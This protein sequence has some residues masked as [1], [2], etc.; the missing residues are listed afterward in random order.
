MQRINNTAEFVEY[1]KH[2]AENEKK[3]EEELDVVGTRKTLRVQL[4]LGKRRDGD[5]ICI[6][7]DFVENGV[8]LSSEEL[9]QSQEE[10]DVPS[11]KYS[12]K[13]ASERSKQKP[14]NV[15]TWL[16]RLYLDVNSEL[17]H[18]LLSE[19][20]LAMKDTLLFDNDLYDHLVMS[21]RFPPDINSVHM[22]KLLAVVSGMH[23]LQVGS[24]ILK[25]KKGLFLPSA[26]NV[27][28]PQTFHE[29][30]RTPQGREQCSRMQQEGAARGGGR[31]RMV[32]SVPEQILARLGFANSVNRNTNHAHDNVHTVVRRKGIVEIDTGIKSHKVAYLDDENADVHMGTKISDVIQKVGARKWRTVDDDEYRV[33]H[34]RRENGSTFTTYKKDELKRVSIGELIEYM[35]LPRG[36]VLKIVHGSEKINDDDGDD[37]SF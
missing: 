25:P 16:S 36:Q 11:E 24:E 37:V 31:G 29:W 21:D 4:A 22:K 8:V 20:V 15:K 6:S 35:Q 3:W 9:K 27:T 28:E 5:P 2:Q 18:G 10:K 33:F 13:K 23:Q 26:Q 17:H 32:E 12:A 14:I 19:M 34:I 1:V 7:S 30:K